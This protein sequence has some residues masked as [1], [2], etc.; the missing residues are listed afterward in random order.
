[1]KLKSLTVANLGP[2]A[3]E[4]H[5]EFGT[6]LISIEGRYTDKPGESN[7]AGKTALID[8]IRFAL[9]GVHRHRNASS[10]VNRKANFAKDN[11]FVSLELDLGEDHYIHIIRTFDNAKQSFITS[12]PE[13]PETLE[14][15]QAE[16]Q[17][18]ITDNILHCT[19]ANAIKTWLVLQN[20][21]PGIMSMSVADRKAFLLDTFSPQRIFPWEAYYQEAG[22][23]LSNLRTRQSSLLSRI[24]TLST[25]LQELDTVNFTTQLNETRSMINSLTERRDQLRDSLK[26]LE[27]AASP[28]AIEE[29][30]RQVKTEKQLELKMYN[31]LLMSQKALDK[32][33][34]DAQSLKVKQDTLAELQTSLNKL[35]KK[36]QGT[37]NATVE[38]EY[39]LVYDRHREQATILSH[40]V[41]LLNKL[42]KFKGVCPVTNQE[43]STGADITAFRTSLENE[44]SKQTLEVDSLQSRLDSLAVQLE[45]YE[46]YKKDQAIIEANINA[47]ITAIQH[48]EGAVESYAEYKE[49]V[50]QEQDAYETQKSKVLQLE[51]DLKSR[52]VDYDLNYQR[53]IRETKQESSEITL[54]LQECQKTLEILVADQQR[55]KILE[56][57]YADSNKEYQQIETRLQALQA[58]RPILSPSGI[59][60]TYLL[61]SITDFE[62]SVNTAMSILG[63]DLSISVE[64]YTYS[65]TLA[66]ICSVCGYQFPAKSTATHCLNPL[67]GAP[68]EY[69]RKETMEINLIGK[70]FDVNFDEDSGGGQQ[71]VSLGVRFA[72]FQILKDKQ[73]MGN[74][75][76]WSLDEVFAPLSEP[77]KLTMLNQLEQVLDRYGIEQLFLITHTD[78]SAILQPSIIIE[79]SEALQESK[80]VS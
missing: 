52:T 27:M 7:R 47:T 78:I 41:T 46:Q 18:Y 50:Q 12:I 10:Y 73:M 32:A 66:P 24:T 13:V 76:F 25:R 5:V 15:K 34:R 43:C 17:T 57:D 23:R 14:L 68:R 60:F 59:P 80:I 9:Y 37:N 21:A 58:L 62:M 53:R 26:D 79:R 30:R 19:Y 38:A 20:D 51:A 4:Q 70:L 45:V 40:N 48:L 8:L 69:S 49:K 44:I 63:T 35:Q 31:G 36:I 77:A 64:P 33:K 71:W 42:A 11:I 74:I 1:M 75:S 2:F 22:T 29:L 28:E 61:S 6:G 16:I 39:T 56:A 65:R 72:L 3:G 55:Q 67:C 54:K